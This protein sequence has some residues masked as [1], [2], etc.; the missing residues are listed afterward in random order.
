LRS[1]TAGSADE[2]GAYQTTQMRNAGVRELER[3]R[4]PFR[5]AVAFALCA[6]LLLGGCST[7]FPTGGKEITLPEI[8]PQA[9]TQSPVTREHQ[10]ILAAYGGAYKNAALEA[11]VKKIADRLAA[12]SDR[13]GL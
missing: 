10:R 5:P 7:W 6:V 4:R 12:A 11:R 2:T 9:K 3:V 8:P 13:P 1:P